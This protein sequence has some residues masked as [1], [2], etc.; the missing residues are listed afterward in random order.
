MV[1]RFGHGH[2]FELG[3]EGCTRCMRSNMQDS[4]LRAA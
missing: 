4:G 2:K 1:D 3:V